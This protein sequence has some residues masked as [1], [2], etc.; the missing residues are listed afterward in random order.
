MSILIDK[1]TRVLVQ[2]IT[3]REGMSYTSRML[4][5]GTLVVAGVTPGKGGEWVAE[6]KIPV[7]ESVRIAVEATGANTSVVFVPSRFATDA[8]YEAVDAGIRLIVCVTEG[9]PVQDMVKLRQYLEMKY[10]RLIGPNCAGVLTPGEGCLGVIP[11]RLAVKGEIGVASRSGT[12]LFEALSI[13]KRHGLGVSSAVSVG[14]D[15]ICGTELVDLLEM[16]EADPHT[17][18]VVLLGEIGSRQEETAAEFIA[19]KMTKP[20]VGFITGFFAPPDKTIGH[21]SALVDGKYG[22]AR[23]KVE[24][25]QRA[26]ARLAASLEDIPTQLV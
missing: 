5:Y 4:D 19:R 13:L 26:G 21:A 8:I 9:I 12:L 17:E 24:A 16:F 20:V 11:N 23:E 1:D 7:F 14:G 2:G 6:G 22:L 3:G 25:L 15:P 18:Q 10:C